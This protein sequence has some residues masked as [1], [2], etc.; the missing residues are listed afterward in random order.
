MAK[1]ITKLLL[2]CAAGLIIQMKM[3]AQLSGTYNVPTNYP[4]LAA[5]ITALN[6]QG[7]SG[8][9]FIDITAGYTETAPVGGYGL[10]ATGTLLNPITFRKSGVGANPLIT[11]YAGGS[12]TPASALQDGVFRLIGSD[13]IT[14]DGIDINDPNTTNPSTME[15]GYGFFKASTSNGCQNN[16]IQN[17][18]IS[19]KT[20]NNATGSGPAVDGSRGINVVNSLFTSQTTVITPISFAGTNSNNKFYSNTV[21]NCNIGIAVIGYSDVSPFTLADLGN[22]IGGSS[23]ANGNVVVNFGGAAAATN[24]AAGVRTL[25]QYNLNVSY[26]NL[27]NNNGTGSNHV[28]VLRGIYVNTAVSANLIATN[29]TITLNAAGTTA[30]VTAIENVSGAT[31]ANN[32][33]SINNNLIINCTYTTNTTGSFLGIYNNAA[34]ASYLEINNNK[35]SN[36]VT[37]ATTGSNYLIYN[38]GAVSNGITINNNLVDNCSNSA[39]TSGSFY[40]IFNNVV[41]SAVLSINS[42]TLSNN[43]TSASTGATQLIYNSSATSN[44][45]TMNNNV[46][47]NCTHSINS[48]GPFYGIYNNGTSP[49]SLE[50]KSNI[51]SSHRVNSFSGSTNLIYNTAAIANS[52]AMSNNVVSNCTSSIT[53]GGSYYVLYNNAGSSGTLDISNNTFST[54]TSAAV[55]GSVHI[56]FNRGAVTN[57]FVTANLNNNLISNCSYSASAGAPFLGVYNSGVTC[58]YLSLSNNTVTGNTWSSVGSLK[59]LVYNTGPVSTTLNL[60][61]NLIANCSSTNNTTGTFNGINNAGTC[62]IALSMCSNTFTNMNNT[63]STG[64]TYLMFNSGTLPGGIITMTNNS[65]GGFTNTATGVGDFYGISNSGTTFSSLDITNTTYSNN[66]LNSSTGA[67]NLIYNTGA[68]GTTINSINLSNNFIS[69]CTSSVNSTGAFYGIYN[70]ACSSASLNINNNTFA[71]NTSY[72]ANGNNHLIYNRGALTNTFS[73][74]NLTNNLISNCTHSASAGAGFYSI[75]NNGITS[76][77]TSITNNTVTSSSWASALAT[78]YMIGNWGVSLTSANISNN[79]ISNNTNTNNTSG[80]LYG[81]YNN[82]SNAISSGALIISNNTF[83]NNSS[84]ATTG[85]THFI[86][87]TGVISNT[88]AS[89]SITNNLIANCA[90]TVNGAGAFYGFYNN[91]A[92]TSNLN[93]SQNTFTNSSLTAS[94]GSTYFIHNRGVA[95]NIFASV[96]VSNNLLAGITHS[97]NSTGIFYG[98]LNVGAATTTCALLALNNNTFMNSVSS[99]TSGQINL[100]NNT[101]PV[102][103]SI[104]IANNL[105]T[106]FTNTITTTG[107]FFV[108][109]NGGNSSLGDLNISNNIFTNI[110][111]TSSTGSR[112]FVYNSGGI[113]NSISIVN[114]LISNCSYSISGNGSSYGLYNNSALSGLSTNISSNTFTNNFSMSTTGNT[115]LFLNSGA[116]TTTL[117]N[118]A[119]SN[120]IV[121]SY[122]NIATSGPFYGIYNSLFTST[123]LS[124]LTNTLSNITMSASTAA[125]QLIYNSGRILNTLSITDNLLTGYSNTLNTTGSFYGILNSANFANQN[126][127][128]N[129]NITNNRFL[130]NT[131]NATTGSIYFINNTG[132]TTNTI[133]TFSI[134]N[135]IFTN[136]SNTIT[137]TGNWYGVYNTA[138]SAGSLSINTNTF[139]NIAATSSN[140]SRMMIFNGGLIVNTADFSSNLVSNFISTVNIAGSYY[141]INNGGNSQ[142]DVTMTNNTFLNHTLTATSGGAQLLY[143]SGIVSNNIN[144]SNNFIS[145]ISHS[146]TSSG[147]FLGIYNNA[148]SSASLNIS[149]N[150]FT[151]LNISSSSGVGY[152]IHNNRATASATI[153]SISI[154]NNTTGA[155]TYSSSSGQFCGVFNNNTSFGNLIVNNNS[156]TNILAPTTTGARYFIYNTGVGST[157]LAAQSNTMSGFTSTLNTS[158]SFYGINNGGNQSGD[159]TIT[160]NTLLNHTL[161][162]TTGSAFVIYNTGSVTNSITIGNNLVSNLTHSATT[163]G[164]FLGLCNSAASSSGLSI[165]TNSLINISLY[166]STG[167]THYI[168]NRGVA[169]STISAITVS[170]NFVSSS[171]HSANSGPFYGIYNNATSFG[172]LNVGGN[173]FANIASTTSTSARYFIYNTGTGSLGINVT[174]NLISNYASSLNTTGIFYDVLNT[175]ASPGNLV[176]SGNTF[177]NQILPATTG[178]SYIIN[179]T[180][181]IS[182]SVSITNNLASSLSHSSTTGI[183]YGIYNA[184]VSCANLSLGTNTL[185]GISTTNSVSVKYLLYN[186]SAASNNISINNNSVSNYSAPLNTTGNFSGIYNTG[187]SQGSFNANNNSFNNI[188]LPA[189]TGSCYVIYTTGTVSST[190]NIDN[191]LISNLTNSS[192]AAGTFYG[193]NN[194]ASNS[195]ALSMS[196]NTFSNTSVTVPT[197][198]VYLV[199]NSGNATTTINSINMNTNSVVNFTNNLGAGALY[200]VFNN[201]ILSA[202]LSLSGNTFSN[203]I[204]TTTG[205]PRYLVYNTG[206]VTSSMNFTNNFVSNFTSSLN[207]VAD[208]YGV[209]NSAFCGGNLDMN[210][211]SFTNNFLEST[212]GN[213]YL[214]YNSASVTNTIG[215]N[216]NIITN[217]TNSTTTSGNFYGLYNAGPATT[218]LSMRGNTFNNNTSAATSGNT[219]LVYNSGAVSN[220]ISMSNNNLGFGFTNNS[221]DYSGTLYNIYNTGGTTT[222]S[223]TVG[224]NIFSGYTYS[225]LAGSGNIYFIHNTNNNSTCDVS[226]NSW[227]NL[228][229]KHNGN[230]YLIYNP[231]STATQLNVNNNT[232]SGFT[233]TANAASLFM[234][235]SNGSSPASCTQIFS[236]NNFSNISAGTQGTGSF[237]GIYNADGTGTSYPKKLVFNNSISNINYS[238]LGFL[239]GYYFDLLG[240]DSSVGSSVSNNTLSAIS[241][242]GPL[243]GLY[244]GGNVSSLYAA[245]VYSNTILNLSSSGTTSDIYGAYLLGGG[246]GLNF[247]KNKISNLT[248]NGILGTADGLRIATAANT[249][250]Y[251]NL[252]GNIQAPFSSATN[253]LNGI[254][255]A[256]G[257]R[258]NLYYNTIYLNAVGTGSSFGSNAL[259]ASTSVSL[260]LR[261]N[262][263]INTS[264]PAG[265]GITTAYRRTANSLMNYSVNSDNNVFYTGIPAANRPIFT[266]GITSHQTLPAYQTF[267]VPRDAASISENTPFLSMIGTNINFL[268]VDVTVPSLTESGGLNIA[269]ITDDFDTQ[270]RQG[271]AGYVGTGT[272]PDIGGD[273]YNQNL[274]PCSSANAG[275]VIV[276]GSSIKCEGERVYL[277]STG[278]TAAG[279]ITQQWKTSSSLTGPFGNVTGGTGANQTAYTTASLS[280]G[281]Y[282]FE[283]VTTC[284]L[285]PVTATS[286][287]ITVTVNAAPSAT[288]SVLSQSVCSGQNLNFT[289]SSNIGINYSWFGPNNFTSTVQ[290]PMVINAITNASGA[291]TLM[292]AD[293]NCTSSPVFVNVLVH[294]TPPSFS[295]TPSASSICIGG[296]QTITA[297]IPISNPTLNFG[298]QTSQNAVS[299]YPAPYSVYYGGQK[300]QIL[301]L[302]AELASAGFTTGTPIQSIQFPVASLGSNWGST[303]N[304]CQNFMVGIKA[305]TVSALSV[306]ET[307]ISNVVSPVNYTPTLGY[308]NIHN[309][310]APFIWDGSSNIVIETVFSNSVAGTSGNTVIQYKTPTGF[311]S[312]LVYRADNQNVSAIAA[313]TTSNVNIGFVRPDFKL[314]GTQVGTYSW[315]PSNGLSSTTAVSV[316]AGPSVTTIYSVALSDG[317]CA[318]AASAS[319]EVILIPTVTIASS[320]QTVC[321]GNTA[322]LTASGAAT[323]TWSTNTTN[324]SIIVAPFVSTTYTL[325]GS[326]PACPNASAT[327]L[328]S[329]APT[330]TLTTLASPAF[331]CQGGSST[332]SVSGAS[333]YT[334][335]G[336]SN[337][338]SLVVSPST[339]TNYTVL[340]YNGPGCWTSKSVNVKVN[341]LPVIFI[342]PSSATICNGESAIFEASGVFS[343]TWSPSN[344]NSPILTVNPGISTSYTVLGT[345]QNNCSNT[346]SVSVLVNACTGLLAHS[347]MSKE[348]ILFPNPTSGIITIQFEFDG[349]KNIRIENSIGALVYE[350]K[351]TEDSKKIDLSAFAKGIYFVKIKG[352][353]ISETFK[354]VSD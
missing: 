345:D 310:S 207:T 349:E 18:T 149:A 282:Y 34:S 116:V 115:Y 296:S 60:S 58:G 74:I 195:A 117:T 169:A 79:L 152:L 92:S 265:N 246:N 274:T 350:T 254:N 46:V 330:L 264:T 221:I 276:P 237:Y 268:H 106:N 29:N 271:N 100:I 256:G 125:Q 123:N 40:N 98:I 243:Y 151:N 80:F 320:S 72:A 244:I 39:S 70:N 64:G 188:T 129:F 187:N 164:G 295:L 37:M 290:N 153:N 51:F 156:F 213:T 227:T 341:P 192:T 242:G 285:G 209:Y 324:T 134:T 19:L 8:A 57:T 175:G 239:Y 200:G 309:F 269:G 3:N 85:E 182:N 65:V 77:L 49:A 343:F 329:S 191:N 112:Y 194:L 159:L 203:C 251:N 208:F 211:N 176:I 313:A 10:T 235:Y 73:V 114:N 155:F 259:Y 43:T 11:A 162:A 178:V 293:A 266:D 231:S 193:I 102:T 238:G 198:S 335:T 69:N 28:N 171:T 344:S 88:F 284:T 298:N 206:S 277:L 334:W 127:P 255:I 204:S 212:T 122:T 312:T 300:M 325:T 202:N 234:Y 306:F 273:E 222:T 160:N 172:N 103:T 340:A 258:A 53:S 165:S 141:G 20:I 47:V 15:Y 210:A 292:V 130:N 321:L 225:G 170:N 229:L 218:N 110:N 75:W 197:T 263:L 326:N 154:T 177:S 107:A 167:A 25:A 71:N 140:S 14:I 12:G 121:D 55:N 215:M 270:I 81:I 113:T 128:L 319:L 67:T 199:Y 316:I 36:I 1:K 260:T 354:V 346:A 232:V 148:G 301:I 262:I 226:N 291:Y 68:V 337:A 338:T 137:S 118:V 196:G 31:A 66:V 6:S 120:N 245:N 307:G 126:S 233:R 145:N 86:N 190:S 93:I 76:T 96:T 157:S 214:V 289:G 184:G 323:Y 147:G 133:N 189:T 279:G 303:L 286:N 220:S 119:M 180:G 132:V 5:A 236:G 275:T 230:E 201:S 248:S 166:T 90:S 104:A 17:C 280:A 87:N 250:V 131:V 332:L 54:I 342:A 247:Y 294:P 7:V 94:T 348:I 179:N 163:A 351:I 143:N 41:S 63:A 174:A 168:Y 181:L 142:G 146:A 150:T 138:I 228:S 105:F 315:S 101:S 23:T 240:D 24:P 38:T 252:V 305:T 257:T 82:N 21:K 30:Q 216:N 336:G 173:T 331:Y 267:V 97:N 124:V 224:G 13:Y 253:P 278:Y 327:I 272:A 261:N 50:M 311:L 352:Q 136:L 322:T 99:G 95:G 83:T 52:I 158:G 59:Y 308:N 44:S 185:N 108:I 91:T 241:W 16:T 61:N 281:I 347:I 42:N 35:F 84:T 26:N 109:N 304:D 299:G 328:I 33:V 297:S 161:S 287:I 205:S 183:L 217:N 45:I 333:T 27:N 288:A 223:L 22:D 56:I 111:S 314:N 283:L 144:I 4:S 339:T 78:R 219:Y 2:C 302:S 317:Q 186:T 135:N 89:V 139:L 32:T 249:T 9:V 318:S 48:T 353:Q 62:T